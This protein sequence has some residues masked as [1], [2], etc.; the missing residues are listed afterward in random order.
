MWWRNIG[1]ER[2]GTRERTAH[3]ELIDNDDDDDAFIM[4]YLIAT[5]IV[6]LR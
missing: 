2:V 4:S 3:N 1:D 5:V 6:R